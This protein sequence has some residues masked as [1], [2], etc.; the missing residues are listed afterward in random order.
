[1]HPPASSDLVP[2]SAPAGA[3]A[4]ARSHRSASLLVNNED[5][6]RIKRRILIPLLGA[7]GILL[8]AF[9][10]TFHLE[11]Q[12]KFNR[13]AART[14]GQVQGLLQGEINEYSAFMRTTIQAITKDEQLAD[15]LRTGDRQ[16]LQQRSQPVLD[17]LSQNHHI[18][19]LSFHRPDRVNLLRVHRPDQSGDLI[20]RYTLLNAAHTGQVFSGIE[21]DPDGTFVLRTVA[22]WHRG[23]EVLGY[24]D[25]G[26]EFQ[27]IAKGLQELLGVDILVAV[28]KQFLDRE[29]W[30]KTA[31][32]QTPVGRMGPV[33]PLGADGQYGV[34][35]PRSAADGAFWG[36]RRAH[37]LRRQADPMAGTLLSGAGLAD[38][39]CG[40]QDAGPH[41]RLA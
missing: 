16:T 23:S 22:P 10:L 9:V 27:E 34:G 33:S 30:Q 4:A 19:R 7:V 29:K 40:R 28:D 36:G 35:S 13:A 3:G 8:A 2:A 17:T 41:V 38:E 5:G 1:M 25:L 37:G 21:C 18:N 14:A 11:Q 26:I 31:R 39:R 12:R 20:N 32:R 15:A 24:I 6:E